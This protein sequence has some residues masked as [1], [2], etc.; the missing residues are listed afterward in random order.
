MHEVQCENCEYDGPVQWE[1]P[2]VKHGR[3]GDV[4]DFCVH[5][6]QVLQVHAWHVLSQPTSPQV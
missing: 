2:T 5:G 3:V 1:E 6:V 4:K